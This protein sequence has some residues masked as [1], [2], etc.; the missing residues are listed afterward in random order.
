MLKEFYME[1]EKITKKDVFFHHANDVVRSSI[2]KTQKIYEKATN[3]EDRI[4]AK[5]QIDQGYH[6]YYSSEAKVFHHH[7]IH[8][9]GND[10]RVITSDKV[11]FNNLVILIPVFYKISI[12]CKVRNHLFFVGVNSS[13]FS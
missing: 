9:Y 10:S 5:E 4:W 3:I 1:H 7:G 8:Q 6:L 12:I 11:T 2:V 13:E